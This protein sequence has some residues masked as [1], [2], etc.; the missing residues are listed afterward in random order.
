M[1]PF[2]FP[3][4]GFYIKLL[5][6]LLAGIA[7]LGC[8]IA[9][10][11]S[12]QCR[13]RVAAHPWRSLLLMAVLVICSFKFVQFRYAMWRIEQDYDKQQAALH[14]TLSAPQTL[15]GIA[16]PSGSRLRLSQ[17]DKPDSYTEAW[18]DTPATLAGLSITHVKRY[19]S[20]TYNTDKQAGE[21]HA[22][23]LN[24]WGPGVQTIAGWSCDTTQQLEFDIPDGSTTPEFLMCQLAAGNQADGIDIPPGST[25]QARNGIT[26]TDGHVEPLRWYVSVADDAPP[27]SVQGIP[28]RHAGLQLDEHH[29]ISS[30]SGNA[31]L[32]HALQL[33]PISYPAGTLVQTLAYPKNRQ[34]PNAL[35]FSPANDQPAQHEDGRTIADGMSVIQQHDGTV[36]DIVS[37]AQAGI[38]RFLSIEVDDASLN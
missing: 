2:G 12:R 32:A 23:T 22:H 24:A 37:N 7:L 16:M 3:S 21:P 33:G 18:F 27:L 38:T 4:Y 9:L 34:H 1:I 11:C 17:Q 13:L 26:Y 14:I 30:V 29:R 15:G 6:S 28:L 20:P 35:V 19:L 25:V 36:L 8:L 10:A 31:E 5:L